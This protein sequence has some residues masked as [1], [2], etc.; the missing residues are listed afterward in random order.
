M[1][2]RT[3]PGSS[4]WLSVLAVDAIRK[5]STS[6]DHAAAEWRWRRST[7]RSRGLPALHT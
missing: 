1:N 7:N 2:Y 3:V 6:G 5:A 4:F